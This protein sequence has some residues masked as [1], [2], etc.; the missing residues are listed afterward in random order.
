MYNT[1]IICGQYAVDKKIVGADKKI[2]GADKKIDETAKTIDLAEAIAIC[3]HCGH[4]QP[5]VQLPLFVITGASGT[6]KS[7]LCQIMPQRMT[8]VVF[9]EMDIYW[10]EAFNT[11]EDGYRAHRELCLRTA[12]NIQQAGLPVVLCGSCVPEQLTACEESRYF[13]AIHY[14]ALVCSDDAI[15]ARLQARPPWRN[16][17]S[18]AFITAM[19]SFNQWFRTEAAR[20]A[21]PITL[22]ATTTQ[23][24]TESAQAVEAWIGRYWP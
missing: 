7:T 9:L 10:Q 22:L 3:P 24:I 5:F 17:D 13:S 2:I 16:T 14:L 20:P 21:A 23:P 6:G 15:A 4:R 12:K 11:P 8:G 19:Q 18:P 1:C